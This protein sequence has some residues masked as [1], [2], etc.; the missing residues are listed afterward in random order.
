M[1]YVR[2]L[3]EVLAEKERQRQL[4][5]LPQNPWPLKPSTEGTAIMREPA[6]IRLLPDGRRL[7]LNDGPIDL[8]VGADGSAAKHF[9][10]VRSCG[11]TFCFHLG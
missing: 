4:T 5:S 1:D 10:C 2:P 6:T 7:H 8:I 11:A 3:G 9:G